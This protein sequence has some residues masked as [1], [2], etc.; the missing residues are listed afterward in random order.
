MTMSPRAVIIRIL[1]VV[2]AALG[3]RLADADPLAVQKRKACSWFDVEPGTIA[4]P[5]DADEEV[6]ERRR[7]NTFRIG[8][9]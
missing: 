9:R 5:G 8:Q 4:L 1:T 6:A 7:R 2:L 3:R